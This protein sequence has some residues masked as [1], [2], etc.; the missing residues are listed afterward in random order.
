MSKKQGSKETLEF[1]RHGL[2]RKPKGMDKLD[3]RRREVRAWKTFISGITEDLGELSFGQKALCEIAFW[4]FLALSEFMRTI[5]LSG[6]DTAILELMTE[7]TNRVFN[8]TSNSFARDLNVIYGP[9][10][11]AKV[12]RRVENLGEYLKKLAE[13]TESVCEEDAEGGELFQGTTAGRTVAV[14]LES[15]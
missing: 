10:G 6:K 9:K 14:E 15:T 7:R 11:L 1:T 2:Y 4:K 3:G 13:K 5:L 12:E 8:V